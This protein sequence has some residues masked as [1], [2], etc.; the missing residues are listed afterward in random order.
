M[1]TRIVHAPAFGIGRQA[2]IVRGKSEQFGT[3]VG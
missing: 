3:D 1:T 2:F